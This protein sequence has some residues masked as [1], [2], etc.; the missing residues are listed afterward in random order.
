MTTK[1]AIS[2]SVSSFIPVHDEPG[3]KKATQA[4]LLLPQSELKFLPIS[5]MPESPRMSCSVRE[6]EWKQTQEKNTG[7]HKLPFEADPSF[8][9]SSQVQNVHVHSL[10]FFAQHVSSPTS[11]VDE[12]SKSLNNC[13]KKVFNYSFL[14]QSK[15]MILLAQLPLF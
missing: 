8:D 15:Q 5:H 10:A 11:K 2:L 13:T 9:T 14:W 4:C 6:R 12:S 1:F 3:L 7:I